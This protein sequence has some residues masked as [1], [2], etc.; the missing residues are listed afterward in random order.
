MR[1]VAIVGGGSAI[2]SKTL[3]LDIMATEALADT[4]FVLMSPTTRRTSM[5]ERFAQEVIAENG[6]SASV[7]ITTDRREALRDADYVITTFRIGGLSSSENCYKIPLKYGL[8]VCVGECVGP[9]GVFGALRTIPVILDVARDMAELCPDALLLNYVNPMAMLCWALGKTTVKY[10]GLCFGVQ[11]TLDLISGYV[12]VPKNEITHVCAGINHM[13]WFTVLKHNGK[14]LYPILKER[15]EKPEYYVNDKVRGELLRQFG[16]FMT[17]SSG[18]MSDYVPWF[19][20]NDEALGLYCDGPML[21]GESGASYKFTE[22]VT[23]KYQQGDV[24]AGEPTK[25]P[26]RSSEY[27]SYILEAIET[28][29]AFRLNGNLRNDGM[30][31]NLPFDCCVDGPVVVDGTGVNRIIVGDLPPQCAALNLT[32]INVQRLGVLAAETGDPELVVQAIAMDPLT[33]AVMTIKEVREMTGELLEAE[34]QWLPL[35]QGKT[36]RRTPVISIPK[37]VKPARVPVD[38]GLAIAA[39][40]GKMGSA[41]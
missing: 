13:A 32:N 12:G 15:F 2:F 1:K 23:A 33:G 22:F 3:L 27:C 16:Y 17:E 11:T 38:P 9:G 34:K 41:W 21:G 26:S 5:V 14:D 36:L 39:Q 29:R 24:L 31:T 20:K 18:H 6:V 10:V 19:R 25:L 37:D 28:D 8:D 30:I 7:S 40:L 35:F 4:H